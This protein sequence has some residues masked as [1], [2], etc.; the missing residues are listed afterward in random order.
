M[1]LAVVAADY[2]PGEA[3]QL[4]RD[5]A[6][7]R[8]SGRI[9]RHRERFISR[10]QAKGIAKEFATQVFEQGPRL[11]RLRLSRKPRRQL[12]P[13]RLRLGMAQAPLSHGLCLRAAQRPAHGLLRARHHRGRRQTARGPGAAG[14]RPAQRLELHPR[15]AS[16]GSGPVRPTSRR[17]P[18]P[19][20]AHGPALRQ[21]TRG[22]R[23][24]A[25]RERPVCRPVPIPD[26]SRLPHRAAPGH[27][28]PPGPS[29]SADLTHFPAAPGPLASPGT[30]GG[31]RRCPVPQDPRGA[32]PVRAPE[33]PR[34]PSSGTTAP[35]TTA[36]GAIRWPTCAR[37]SPPRA[38]P[39][40]PPYSECPTAAAWTTSASSSAASA[41]RP[42]KASS[43]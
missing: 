17:R 42:P 41:P 32:G 36:L 5:M 29:R 21:G 10:M 35:P 14:G 8:R 39:T 7:W 28:R 23:L 19:R 34:V 4:R 3:D 9:E 40:P 27:P 11:R 25:H 1:R 6:A 12:R 33:R 26:R 16:G 13:H 20:P 38:F 30:P 43:S 18:V 37:R 2:T 24:A 31:R 22:S 15:K